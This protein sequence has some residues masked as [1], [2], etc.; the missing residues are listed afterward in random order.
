MGP[1]VVG[2]GLVSGRKEGRE[3]RENIPYEA[4]WKTRVAESQPQE[5]L[6]GRTEERGCTSSASWVGRGPWGEL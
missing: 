6:G 5:G 2:V 3:A 4:S 1:A